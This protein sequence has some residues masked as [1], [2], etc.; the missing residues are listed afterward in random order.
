MRCA[1]AAPNS[2]VAIAETFQSNGWRRRALLFLALAPV[3]DVLHPLAEDAAS[4]EAG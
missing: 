3:G 2:L 1:L 4:E